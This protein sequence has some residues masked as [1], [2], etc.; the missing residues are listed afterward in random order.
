MP[1]GQ[2]CG[3]S[4]SASYVVEAAEYAVVDA[5]IARAERANL[6]SLTLNGRGSGAVGIE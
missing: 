3:D 1:S 6:F 2:I 4:S 5:A